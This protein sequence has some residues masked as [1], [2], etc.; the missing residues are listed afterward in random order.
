MMAPHA[1]HNA[2]VFPKTRYP[3]SVPNES[4]AILVQ[5][6]GGKTTATHGVLPTAAT[7][8]K[9]DIPEWEKET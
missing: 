6:F 1:P 7:T 2:R 9:I 3:G 4:Y 8:A 5:G